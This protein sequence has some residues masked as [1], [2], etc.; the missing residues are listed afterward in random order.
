MIIL[1]NVEPSCRLV[2]GLFCATTAREEI[3][4]MINNS[5]A[6]KT[7]GYIRVSTEEQAKSD[8]VSLKAQREAIE[9]WCY[10]NGYQV[11][12]FEDAGI[13]G[14]SVNRPAFNVLLQAV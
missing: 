11:E 5:N 14:R 3:E 10:E 12:I 2:C 13:S 6:Q 7:V 8:R 9:N 4:D 1:S